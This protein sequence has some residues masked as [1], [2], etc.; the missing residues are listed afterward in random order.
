M[1]FNHEY[2]LHSPL[3]ASACLLRFL[4]WTLYLLFLGDSDSSDEFNPRGFEMPV[5]R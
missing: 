2:C 1:F 3:R 5:I 4:I